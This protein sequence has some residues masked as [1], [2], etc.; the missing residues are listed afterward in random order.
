ML[1]VMNYIINHSISSHKIVCTFPESPFLFFLGG[2]GFFFGRGWVFFLWVVGGSILRQRG[3][4]IYMHQPSQNHMPRNKR[5]S[6]T[7]RVIFSFLQQ[8]EL[9]ISHFKLWVIDQHPSVKHLL[10]A[11]ISI[12]P[13]PS[14]KKNCSQPKKHIGWPKDQWRSN[15]W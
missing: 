2:W 12:F 15:L 6:F 7:S 11:S 13:F 3:N 14:L 9:A 5:W 10:R 4:H 8:E 1:Y